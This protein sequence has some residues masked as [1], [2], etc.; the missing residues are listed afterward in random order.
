MAPSAL[1][2]SGGPKTDQFGRVLRH[3]GTPIDGLYAVGNCA[4]SL[5]GQAYLG[6][7]ATLAPLPLQ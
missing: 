3:D 5:F 1:D 4:G 6:A 7:G 2:T